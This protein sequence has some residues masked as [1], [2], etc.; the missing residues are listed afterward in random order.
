MTDAELHQAR[1]EKWHLDGRPV[2]TLDEARSFFESAGFCTMY[3]LRPA[4]PVP[5]FVGAWVGADDR[6]PTWQH[7]FEDP[8]AKEATD[9]MVRA[10]R[11]KAVYEAP[12]FDE[13]NAF[14]VAASVFP[15]FYALVGE[16]NPKQPP[17]GTSSGGYSPLACDAFEMIRKRGPISKAKLGEMLGGSLSV[18]GLDRA[19]GELWAKLRITRVDYSCE[20]ATCG[21]SY[22]PDPAKGFGGDVTV[23]DPANAFSWRRR[24]AGDP[25]M[26]TYTAYYEMPVRVCTSGCP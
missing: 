21:W 13:N 4:V 22:H 18:A 11:D 2:R 23:A 10:L 20:G 19:L 24:W 26:D 12:L 3:P 15:Y 14:L 16:R 5:T 17:R 6:L 8:R 1:A 25:A 9:L 7:V